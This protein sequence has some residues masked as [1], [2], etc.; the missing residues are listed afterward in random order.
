MN[1][2]VQILSAA[3]ALPC[4]SIAGQLN[5]ELAERHAA[6]VVAP[7]GA[8]KSTLLPLTIL[9]AIPEGRVIMLEPRRLAARQ[10]AERMAQL[11]G[12]SVGKTVGYQIRFERKTSP[13]TRIEV[14]TEGILTRRMADDGTLDGVGCIIFDEFH[15]RSIQSDTAFCLAREIRSVLRPDLN[16]VVMSATIDATPICKALNAH[17][18]SCEGR[19]FHVETVLADEDTEAQHVAEGVA[20][21]ICKAHREQ[22]GDILAFL[23]G[24]ADI[25]RCA[26]LL[27]DSLA[28][29]AVCPLYG[30]LDLSS[31]RKAIAPSAEGQ[32]KVVLATSIAETSLTIEGVK[33]VVDGGYCRRLVY[34]PSNGLSHLETVR[35]SKD[36]ARQR[37]G[38]AGRVSPGVCYRLWTLATDH[39]M[40]EQRSP[41]ICEADLT[42]MVLEAADFGETDVR[43]MPWLT[44]PPEANVRQAYNQLRALKAI[45]SDG[46]ITNTGRRMAV[47]PC[48]PRIARMMLQ[49]GSSER[50]ALACDIAA[51]LEE[52]DVMDDNRIHTDLA[53]RVNALRD[54]RRQK[55]YGPWSRIA[56][57][58]GEYA[59]MA[60]VTTDNAY[61]TGKDAGELLAAGYPERIAMKTGHNGAY[62]LAGG[63]TVT[64]DTA[65]PQSAYS[66]LVVALLH[67]NGRS[68]GRAFMAAPVDPKSLIP[69][70]SWHDNVTWI[71]HQGGIVARRERRIGQLV[72]ESKPMDDIGNDQLKRI[73]CG[74]VTKEGAGLLNWTEDVGTL[75]RRVELVAKWH[76][77]LNLPDLSTTRMLRTAQEWLPFFLERDGKVMTTV[78]ELRKTDLRM[79]LWSQLSYDQQCAV[80]RLAPERVRVPSGSMIRLDY[81]Q[82]SD[83]PVLSVRLQ[84][85]FGLEDTPRVDDGKVAVLME[86]LSPGFKPVQLTSDL[87]SF[88]QTTYFDVRKDLRRRYP[89]HDWPDNPLESEAVRGV[90]RTKK[91]K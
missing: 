37:A 33:I 83:V 86:L 39:R 21:A 6:V 35:I 63:G 34:A 57:V 20:A 31:Q 45:D 69:L 58:A 17:C 60:G 70:T 61:I 72:V 59:R 75:Q 90:K 76:P 49:A 80:D 87:R 22:E 1:Q 29:T 10:V 30:N 55:R 74:A 84:E 65:D 7:P 82:G 8:G 54:A 50:R 85:C 3:S 62:S 38:R 44:P 88:W 40:E 53:A 13:Q 25:M 77:E 89:K 2:T 11:L 27:G 23:P 47:L 28:P 64:L 51:I 15:E 56:R 26:A 42:P 32:R 46:R 73:V 81:R 18:I 5:M 14:V 68:A 52:K 36:M 19:M 67:A 66:W 9:N 71:T 24:Q 78:G 79:I 16:L 12:E 48:H 41:E 43:S 91:Q 4:A